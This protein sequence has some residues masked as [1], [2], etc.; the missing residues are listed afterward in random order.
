MGDDR[1]SADDAAGTV[2][3]IGDVER[4]AH[5][6][7]AELVVSALARR[8]PRRRRVVEI[9]GFA[10]AGINQRGGKLQVESFKQV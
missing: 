5:S 10:D 2:L 7:D 4:V 3:R 9:A 6:W 1:W 8:F